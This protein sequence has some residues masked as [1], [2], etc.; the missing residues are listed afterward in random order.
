M[1]LSLALL[2]TL[3]LAACGSGSSDTSEDAPSLPPRPSH[4][5]APLLQVGG[6]DIFSRKIADIMSNEDM[7]NGQTIVISNETDAPARWAATRL[8]P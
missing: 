5:P 3:S 4:G 1:A 8:P 6:S 2:M 7:V